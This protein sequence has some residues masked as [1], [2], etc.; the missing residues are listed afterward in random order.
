MYLHVCV[1]IQSTSTKYNNRYTC[2]DVC[3]NIYHVCVCVYIYIYTNERTKH[4]LSL[5]TRL[6]A[7][8]QVSNTTFKGCDHYK[9][10]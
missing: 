2:M 10:V 7:L 6:M 1:C 3:V 5:W 4:S 9:C 8:V